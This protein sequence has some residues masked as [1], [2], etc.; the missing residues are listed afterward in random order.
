MFRV[1]ADVLDMQLRYT[2]EVIPSVS[3]DRM[4]NA[5]GVRVAHAKQG[6]KEV[7]DFEAEEVFR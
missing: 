4:P 6:C 7:R 1:Q 5:S 3:A 2:R